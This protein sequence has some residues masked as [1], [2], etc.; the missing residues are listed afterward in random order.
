MLFTAR[1][2]TLAAQLGLLAFVLIVLAPLASQLRAEPTD[3]RWLNELGCHEGAGSVPVSLDRGL[4]VLQADACGYC[5][6]FSH[7]PALAED[8]LP[9][10]GW[11][12][13][14][15]Q[16]GSVQPTQ[17]LPRAHFPHALSRA[18]PMRA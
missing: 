17:P 4:P 3:W 10:A 2:R 18:P 13:P 11:L 12:G 15:H 5:S 7:C 16:T 6:L 14:L 9:V 1:R 8:S